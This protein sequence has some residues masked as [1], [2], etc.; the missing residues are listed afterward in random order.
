MQDTTTTFKARRRAFIHRT[1]KQFLRRVGDF[2]AHHSLVPTT[3]VLSNDTFPWV[4]DLE[5]HWREVRGELDHLLEHPEDIPSFHQISPDQARISKGDNW[6]T[7]TFYALGTRIDDNCTQC[8]IT[9]GLLDRLPDLQNAWFSILAPRYHIPPHKG[10]S[11]AFIRC[12][13]AL[14][15]PAERDKCW[16][17][18]DDQICTWEE[19]HCLV[20]DDTYEHEVLNDTDERRAVLFLDFNRPMDRIGTWFNR[21][22]LRLI[23]SSHYFK[24]PMRNLTEW[25]KRR[26]GKEETE[27]DRTG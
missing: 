12:H 26:Q 20:F 14:K 23:R 18:V 6:K 22:L 7:F 4:A 15:V 21:G 5:A 11:R 17:R 8:P 9:A 3:P 10:P 16:I 19:G 24:D 13:L 25:N 2:Q 27:E 1:G